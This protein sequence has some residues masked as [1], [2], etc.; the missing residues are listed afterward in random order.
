[1]PPFSLRELQSGDIDHHKLIGTDENL[2]G[3]LKFEREIERQMEEDERRAA[4][5]KK[6][7]E[8]RAAQ[9]LTVAQLE[10]LQA[11][12]MADDIPLEPEIM[13][14]WQIEEVQ[15]FFESGGEVRPKS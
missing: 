4:E 14:K 3:L 6:A 11:E 10:A 9:R 8:Q 1:M 2:I 7:A 5:K 13:A 15:I 12:C